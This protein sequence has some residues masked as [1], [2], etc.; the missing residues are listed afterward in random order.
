MLQYDAG[1]ITPAALER[2]SGIH[3]KQLWNYLHGRSKPRRQQVEKIE[4][5]LHSLGN[6]LMLIAL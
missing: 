2:L 5:A 3:Q 4:K 1:V 6:E